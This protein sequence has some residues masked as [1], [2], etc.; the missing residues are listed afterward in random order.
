[1]WDIYKRKENGKE[2]KN[3]HFAI[4][5]IEGYK[6]VRGSTGTANKE[7]A[8]AIA[9]KAELEII[10]QTKLGKKKKRTWD[11]AVERW[12][13]E[14]EDK[15]KNINSDIY[16]MRILNTYFTGKDLNELTLDYI[17]DLMED[18]QDERE[19]SNA[20]INRYLSLIRVI[21]RSAC[22][23]WEWIEKVPHLT[24]RNEN[25]SK[26]IWIT[27]NEARR[28]IENA[29]KGHSQQIRLGFATGLRCGNIYNLRWEQVDIGQ[30]IIRI[31]GEEMK[32]GKALTIPL[33]D[34][35]VDVLKEQVGHHVNFV[36][37]VLKP[38]KADT[39][40][41]W[42]AKGDIRKDFTFH[43]IRHTWAS[44]HVQAG[45]T[46]QELKELGG[47]STMIMVLRYAHLAP[48]QLHDAAKNTK[49][50]AKLVNVDLINKEKS[51]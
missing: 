32:S 42:L 49:L 38:V 19:L 44:W 46:L 34:D 5:G 41:K 6:R 26:I 12:R 14:A 16:R 20:T 36:F 45:T 27:Q 3:W 17:D 9:R 11:E 37:G 35:A 47:W 23:R 28:L 4:T 15:R 50:N 31:A 21:L 18:L 43:S 7:L 51:L 2:S 13:R 24:L 39:W 48:S 10:S 30:R 8:Q 33:N 25:N 1:M 29:D 40:R 22:L